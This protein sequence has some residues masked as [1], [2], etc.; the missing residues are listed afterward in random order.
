M[1]LRGA[2]KAAWTTDSSK[3][4]PSGGTG[5]LLRPCR[6]QPSSS[7]W[8]CSCLWRRSSDS[9]CDS[10][11][12]SWTFCFSHLKPAASNWASVTHLNHFTWVP[13]FTSTP[14]TH[15]L[16][17]NHWSPQVHRSWQTNVKFTA[18]TIQMNP[19]PIQKELT[20]NLIHRGPKQQELTLDVN[21]WRRVVDYHNLKN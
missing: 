20:W 13:V 14:S 7:S 10:W 8:L 16:S 1:G 2:A 21:P 11:I 12:A 9:S 5:T 18:P 4:F 17:R 6:W 3:Q 19:T 15:S